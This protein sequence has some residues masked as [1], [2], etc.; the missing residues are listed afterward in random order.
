MTNNVTR[1][2]FGQSD[3]R[4]GNNHTGDGQPPQDP[5]MESRV[6]ALETRLDAT[7][8]TLATKSDMA[9]IETRVTDVKGDLNISLTALRGDVTTAIAELKAEV[10]RIHTDF[11]RWMIATVLSIMA[12]LI[13]G[14]F[15]VANIM[16][17]SPA[18]APQSA[19]IVIQVPAY[20]MPATPPAAM[21]LPAEPGKAR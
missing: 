18:P 19:P 16:K 12:A 10:H 17:P 1:A 21:A 14:L 2:P 13:A 4:K 6:T 8:P 9:A 20:Q 7:L 5:P 11:S 3:K 15:G